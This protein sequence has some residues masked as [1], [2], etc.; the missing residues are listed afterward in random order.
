VTF[1]H[2]SSLIYAKLLYK[3]NKLHDYSR[4]NRTNFNTDTLIIGAGLTGIVL[5]TKLNVLGVSNLV[6]EKSKG[7]GGRYASRRTGEDIFDHGAQHVELFPESRNDY[8]TFITSPIDTL[9]LDKTNDHSFYTYT[10][11]MTS[12][13]KHH[14]QNSKILFNTK[15]VEITKTSNL[16][17]LKD[18]NSNSYLACKLILTAPLPQSLKLL[19][20]SKIKYPQELDKISYAKKI[21]ILMSLKRNA[22]SENTLNWQLHSDDIKKTYIQNKK[23]NNSN[24]TFTLVMSDEFSN[25]NFELS[26][27]DLQNLAGEVFRNNTSILDNLIELQVKKWR[28]AYPLNG[29]NTSYLQLFEKLYLAGDAFSGHENSTQSN[30]ITIV[31][32]KFNPGNNAYNSAASLACALNES[33]E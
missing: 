7:V 14:S 16:W 18:E 11:G 8:K 28:Y 19:S 21:V 3:I 10:Q 20:D 33:A 5:S 22:V 17:C 26:D 32:P 1:V 4:M 9:L 23:R 27:S 25:K 29:L 31:E 2:Q 6:L 13:I 12:L 24:L 30:K 15:I